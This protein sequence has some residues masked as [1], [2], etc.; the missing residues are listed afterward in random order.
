MSIYPDSKLMNQTNWFYGIKALCLLL[1]FGVSLTAQPSYEVNI[2]CG[3]AAYVTTGGVS[4]SADSLFD[5]GSTFSSSDPIAGTTDDV[6]YQSERYH[7][8]LSYSFPVPASGNYDVTLHFAEVFNKNQAVNKRVFDL[9]LEGNLVLDDYDIFASVGGYTADVKTFQVTVTDGVLNLTCTSDINKAKLCAIQVKYNP[10][11]CNNP[12]HVPTVDTVSTTIC[13]GDSVLAQGAY[14]TVA[15]FYTDTLLNQ[16]ACDSVVVTHLQVTTCTTPAFD[17]GINCGGDH[18]TAV[19]GFLFHKDTLSLNGQVFSNN[20]TVSNTTDPQLYKSERYEVDLAYAIPV[21]TNGEYMVELHFAE[22]FNKNHSNGKRVFDMTLENTLVLDDYDIYADVG[23]D[24]AAVKTFRIDVQDGVLSLSSTSS[25]NNAKLCAIRITSAPIDCQLGAWSVW[26][27]CD[28]SC[29]GGQQFRTRPV[30]VAA[31]NGG[32]PCGPTIEY[33]SCNTQTCPTDCQVSAWSAWSS[34]DTTCGGGQQFRTRQVIVPASNGGVACPNLIEFRACNTQVCAT[35]G[36][37]PNDTIVNTSASGCYAEVVYSLDR[38]GIKTSL[39]SASYQNVPQNLNDK[40]KY[41]SYGLSTLELTPGG[42]SGTATGTDVSLESV[43][44]KLDH[45][46]VGDLVIDLVSPNGTVVRLIERPGKYGLWGSGGC[47]RDDIDA[48]FVVGTGNSAENDCSGNKPVLSGSYTAH[49]GY[50]LAS[51]ND[52]SDPNGKWKLKVYD[53]V[54]KKQPKLQGWSLQF[55]SSVGSIIQIAGL[56]S[57]AQFPLGVTTNTLV[58]TDSTGVSDT[59]SFNVTVEDNTAPEFDNCPQDV[60]V[61]GDPVNWS[62]PTATDNCSAVT[63]TQVSGPSIGSSLADGTYAVSYQAVDANG[64]TS[65]CSFNL[66]KGPLSVDA[67][68]DRIIYSGGNGGCKLLYGTVQGGQAPYTY[69]WSSGS[70]SALAFVC[71]TT[72]TDYILTVTDVNGCTGSDTVNVEVIDVSCG[73]NKVLVCYNDVTYCVNAWVAWYYTSFMGATYG[74]CSSSTSKKLGNASD[75]D[76][77]SWS[78]QSGKV[79]M[80]QAYPNPFTNSTNIG[81]LFNEGETVD[82]GLYDL[83]G[84]LIKVIYQGPN[85]AGESNT[86]D[87]DGG[88]LPDGV[89]LIIARTEYSTKTLRIH[90]K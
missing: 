32:I 36:N 15:G 58:F 55:R 85:L 6:L 88:E 41:S 8:T 63:V 77:M 4:Y 59:C 5:N 67:G 69:S 23:A 47:S 27:A 71:P 22:T 46:R 68:N 81:W 48:Y 43:Y 82:I 86:I 78:N 54:N 62:I 80:L 52:G 49:N 42:I 40:P 9:N 75:L 66:I 89:Y 87:F 12:N 1:L 7:N 29:G 21:P 64:N 53:L 20:K 31:A 38:S 25:A 84:R 74:S 72:T 28:V 11:V 13:N 83:T 26:S 65:L 90:H 60:T 24:A 17:F 34:C 18:Y 30:L 45:K 19:D 61:C 51:M 10:P 35:D 44:L 3:G 16:N 79:E 2:N 37:C 57:G 33:R 14:Q 73:N 39:S 50:D 56:P 76:L 70:N